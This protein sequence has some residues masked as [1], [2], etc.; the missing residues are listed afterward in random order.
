VKQRVQDL[1]KEGDALFN[2][3]SGLHSLWQETALQFYPI[4]ADFTTVHCEGEEF[5]SHLMTGRPVLAHR[6]LGNALSSM[7]RPRGTPWFHART[8][9]EQINS[10]AGAKQWLDHKSDVMRRV[11]YDKRSQ[12]V[13]ATKEGDNDFVC[14]GQCVITVE[15]NRDLNG[16]LYRSWHLRD[17]AWCENAELVI[18]TVHRKWDIKAVNLINLFPK[19][20]SDKVRKDAEKEPYKEIKCRHI[21]MPAD[22]YDYGADSD[23]KVNRDRFPFVSIYVDVDNQTILEEVPRK[24]LAM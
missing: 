10:D 13:R 24:R 3:R 5:A 6:D 23:K 4:R 20:V 22:Q 16:I 19:T 8:D 14:F 18:D 15:P 17:T 9:D 21:V 11:M 1:I 12:F 2:K 7:L